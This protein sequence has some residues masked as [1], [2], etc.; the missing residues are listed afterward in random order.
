VVI[1]VALLAVVALVA[2]APL[3]RAGDLRGGDFAAWPASGLDFLRAYASGWTDLGG[4]ATP[5]P[6][7]PAQAVLGLLTGLVAGNGWLAARLILLGAPLVAWVAAYRAATTVT[8][9]SVARVAAASVYALSPPTIAVLTTGDL[10]GLATV[11]LL[12]VLV[13]VGRRVASTRVA[14]ST[15]WRA[16]AAGAIVLAVAVAFEPSTAWIAGVLLAVAIVAVAM[17]TG[18]FVERRRAVVRL[19]STGA[20]AL[21]LLFPWS[22]DLFASPTPLLSDAG[23]VSGDA[24]FVRWLLLSPDLAGFPPLVVGVAFPAAGLLAL[25]VASPRRPLQ[26]GVLWST[27]LVGTLAAWGLGRTPDQGIVASGLVL[28]VVAAAYAGLLA[29]GIGA[30]AE[31]LARHAFGWRQVSAAILAAAV[32]V[33]MLASV[34]HLLGDPWEGF[35]V[36]I[37]ALPTFLAADQESV[38][39]YRVLVLS[40]DGATV[41]WDATG[42][43]G[44][45]MLHFGTA[46]PVE[47]AGVIDAA[48]EAIV[49]RTDPA[50]AA[51]LGLANFRYLYVPEGGRSAELEAALG[52]Q[53][54]L[55]PLAVEQGLV[56]R[57][58]RWLPRAVFADEQTTRAL[59]AQG[60]LPVGAR[61]SPLERVS[62]DAYQGTAPGP[63]SIFLGETVAA[64]WAA[65]AD[66]RRLEA[67]TVRG[68]VRFG[69][70]AAAER[71]T[72]H[73]SAQRTRSVLVA[74]QAGLAL[75]AVSLV[76]R[77]PAFVRDGA[78]TKDRP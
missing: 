16:T 77:P 75:L 71:V 14:A 30:A 47:L 38:G 21:V 3:L 74:L 26:V 7:S 59:V 27:V 66:G 37:P 33:G 12:P 40:Q 54:D 42:P 23:S 15:A 32:S 70:P 48:V 61:P 22:A 52:D 68:L 8:G 60:E 63:G 25:L 46:A 28:V 56:F 18:P 76:L 29:V 49:V 4:T 53:F 31:S 34:A 19:A 43:E 69:V 10:G 6:T 35:D 5:G 57:V 51:R 44:P 72:V 55:E 78:R 36:G 50:A 39:A 17:S 1:T 67:T 11:A 62:D 2:V 20:G 45:T 73:Y 24:P 13:S 9:S 64:G 58:E 41:R 65:E